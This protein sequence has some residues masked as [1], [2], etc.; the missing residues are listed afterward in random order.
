MSGYTVAEIAVWLLLA[1][2]LGFALGWIVRELLL[3]AGQESNES[4]AVRHVVQEPVEPA[5]PAKKA[6][7]KKT[8]AKKAPAKKAPAKKTAAKKT[9]AK[10]GVAKKAPATKATNRVPPGTRP[11]GPD[12]T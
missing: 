6:V 10:K 11:A 3:R 2:A 1:T 8:V 4:P 12:N 7:A 9:P 5:V